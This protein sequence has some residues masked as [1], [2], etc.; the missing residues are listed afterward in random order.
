MKSVVLP[1]QAATSPVNERRLV[2]IYDAI[3]RKLTLL[4]SPFLL[5]IRLYWGWQFAQTG[6]GKLH[7]LA[8]IT[9]FFAS[10]N[11]PFPA[12]SAHFVSGLEFV[13]GLLLIVGLASR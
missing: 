12:F 2:H 9:G 6:W 8:K 1:V 7:N 10:L 11:I 3:S 13:G 5:A 4:Q